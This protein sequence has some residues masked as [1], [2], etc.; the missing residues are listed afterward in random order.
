MKQYEVL[1]IDTVENMQCYNIPYKHSN[2][3]E[4]LL[5]TESHFVFHIISQ[6]ILSE[7]SPPWLTA[8]FE[9]PFVLQGSLKT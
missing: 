7:T 9:T 5:I 6:V 2:K 8:T 4:L 1:H 3:S